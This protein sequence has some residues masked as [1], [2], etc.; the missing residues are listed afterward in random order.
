MSERCVSRPPTTRP[1][2]RVGQTH[3]K[4][5]KERWHSAHKE[6]KGKLPGLRL[7]PFPAS[8]CSVSGNL[9]HVGHGALAVMLSFLVSLVFGSAQA[10]TIFV[11]EGFENPNLAAWALVPCFRPENTISRA[12]PSASGSFSARLEV[13]PS[14][15]PA[16]AN[17]N[18]IMRSR[19]T[20]CFAG[21]TAAEAFVPDGA[22]RASLWMPQDQWLPMDTEAWYGFSMLVA[23]KLEKNEPRLI[24][25][26]WKQSIGLSPFLAQRFTDR[27]FYITLEQDGRDGLSCRV[28]LAYQNGRPKP[29]RASFLHDA[30]PVADGN[31]TCMS[32]LKVIRPDGTSGAVDTLPNPFRKC[33]TYIVYRIKGSTEKHGTLQS[34]GLVDIWV[35]GALVVSARG[36]IGYYSESPS[37]RLRYFKFGPYRDSYV[38]RDYVTTAFLDSF[39]RG[40]SYSE[41]DPMRFANQ[42]PVALCR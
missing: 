34:D 22:E 33:W 18:D 31:S 25:G 15:A 11:Q 23:G 20:D 27:T 12:M 39:T 5:M 17:Q 42:K 13:R 32:D 10:S 24:I 28:L 37:M 41:V 30:R 14:L 35:N 9:P 16:S 21:D 7:S 29:Q 26:Q 3:A 38:G 19:G 2:P 6:A 1:P 40:S 4:Q 8:H 36:R